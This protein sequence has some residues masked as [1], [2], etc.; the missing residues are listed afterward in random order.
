[1]HGWLDTKLTVDWR[2]L[3]GLHDIVEPWRALAARAIEPNAFYEPA[4]ALAA[5]AAFGPDAHA[6][7]VWAPKPA[8]RLAGFFPARIG[9]RFGMGP[10]L[11]AGWIHPFAML[12]TPLVDRDHS[13]AV[14]ATWLD[15]VGGE[16]AWPDVA[17]LP[18]CSA[19]GPFAAALERVLASRG[20][21]HADFGLHRRALLSPGSERKRYLARSIGAR[22]RKELPRKRRRLAELGAVSH[23]VTTVEE[24]IRNALE[25]FFELEARGW[26]GRRGTAATQCDKRLRFFRTAVTGLARDGK[27]RIDLLRVGE[28]VIA[29]T[30]ALRSGDS[31]FGWKM[32]YDEAFAKYS[33]GAQLIL[34]LTE[35]ALADP[36]LARID[37]CAEANHPLIDHLW[38]DRFTVSDRLLAL[39]GDRRA[40]FQAACL[41]EK[42]RRKAIRG[43]KA[44]RDR[45]R[46]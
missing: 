14:I 35:D 11:L 22:H 19:E 28:R 16:P 15:R 6:L 23:E 29:T 30:I 21:P 4:F 26:K 10:R 42:T 33:P 20:L 12:G 24:D 43:A 13:D 25:C 9:R 45:L 17:L 31:M 27:A 2:P 46:G 18:T 40:A 1:M 32:A 7:L 3:A 38:R 39:R 37:S 8:R 41:V 5:A 36:A 34:N 44:V